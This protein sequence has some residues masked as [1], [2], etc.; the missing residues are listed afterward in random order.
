MSRAFRASESQYSQL[1]FTTADNIFLLSFARFK[2]CYYTF[3][4]RAYFYYLLIEPDLRMA[5]NAFSVSYA[6]FFYPY[7]Y[8]RASVDLSACGYCDRSA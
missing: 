5:F 8:Y 4:Q 7:R 2:Y 1:L 6:F 3:S